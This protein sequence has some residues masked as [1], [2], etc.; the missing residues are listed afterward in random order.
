MYNK[1]GT[2]TAVN[3]VSVGDSLRDWYGTVVSIRETPKRRYF[4]IQPD[5]GVKRARWENWMPRDGFVTVLGAGA[6]ETK[7]A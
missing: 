5:P 7:G 1:P 3:D 4:L 2:R 6:N